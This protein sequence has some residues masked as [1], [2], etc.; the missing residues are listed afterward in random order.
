MKSLAFFRTLGSTPTSD[1]ACAAAVHQSVGVF[2]NAA[3]TTFVESEYGLIFV[4]PPS[5]TMRPVLPPTPTFSKLSRE[6]P[7]RLYGQY[8]RHMRFWLR[9]SPNEVGQSVSAGERAPMSPHSSLPLC[10]AKL[11][12]RRG[13]IASS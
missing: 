6:A 10:A 3:I 2:A 11:S 1:S 8:V 13:S 9:V 7:V 12:V 4:P 5:Q